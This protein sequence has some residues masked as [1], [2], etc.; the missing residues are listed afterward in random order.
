MEQGKK[1]TIAVLGCGWLGLPLAEKLLA[2][3]HTIKGS[4]TSKDKLETLD[5]KGIQAYLVQCEEDNCLGLEKFVENVDVLILTLPPRLRQNSERRF[6][7]VIKNLAEN[8][9]HS[10]IKHLIFI[11]STSVYGKLTGTIDENSMPRPFSESGKQLLKCEELLLSATQYHTTVLRF[12]GLIGPNRHPVYSLAKRDAIVNPKG[13]INLIHLEDCINCLLAVIEKQ[14]EN[15][16]FNAVTP[17][18]PD[19]KSYYNAMAEKAGISLPP[20]IVTSDPNRRILS[21]KIQTQL[22]V[23]F[24]V[25]NLLTLN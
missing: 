20:F 23:K 24:N 19:R 15:S 9:L 5:V 11:S 6:D 18:H 22:G 8:I 14:K 16:V 3:G 1:K 13:Q 21:N 17:F 2:L 4:T 12:G 10:N 7:L 25:E